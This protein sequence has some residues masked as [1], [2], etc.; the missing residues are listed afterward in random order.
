MAGQE[1]E[2]EGCDGRPQAN[3]GYGIN[4]PDS[5]HRLG[6]ISGQGHDGRRRSRWESVMGRAMPT[7]I[8]LTMRWVSRTFARVMTRGE[9]LYAG[10]VPEAF[11]ERGEAESCLEERR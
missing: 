11:R 10:S 2:G 9:G 5:I 1:D 7:V 6:P 4:Q 3:T 8:Q